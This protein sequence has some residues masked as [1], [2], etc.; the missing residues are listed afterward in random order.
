MGPVADAA[1]AS[2]GDTILVELGLHVGFNLSTKLANDLVFDKPINKLVPIHSKR[3]ETTG[4]KVLLITLRYKSTMD[5]AALGFYRSSVHSDVSLFAAVKDYLAVEK[6]WFSPYLFASARRPIIPRNMKPDIIFCHGPFRSVTSTGSESNAGAAAP[7][8]GE[9]HS[10]HRM[11]PVLGLSIP[12]LSNKF[13]RSRTPSPEPALTTLPPPPVPR[14]MVILLV[15]LKPHRK[16]WTSSARPGESVI[17]YI[18]L[19]GCP[20]IVVPVKV[21]APLVAWDGLTL[22]Q[23]WEV[24]LPGTGGEKS[25]SGKFEGVVNVLFEY[26]DLCMDWERVMVA[27]G[28][29]AAERHQ[30]EASG[31]LHNQTRKKSALKNV[32]TLLVAGAVRS[33]A[34]EEAKKELDPERSG[35][36]MWRIP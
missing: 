11:F 3:L 2:F 35:I 33:K 24:E 8:V 18:L 10:H 28:G 9:D 25:A 32:V 16:I 14:R 13:S 31:G 17:N 20:S 22:Q 19:N 30:A 5:D 21:G 29:E 26:L 34:S 15:G 4:V 6:G 7:N 1:V 12:A 23:L 27:T 36:A